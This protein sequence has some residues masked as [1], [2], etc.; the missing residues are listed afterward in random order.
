MVRFVTISHFLSLIPYPDAPSP[1]DASD[2]AGLV[3]EEGNESDEQD[4]DVEACEDEE[5]GEDEE[6]AGE[7][8]TFLSTA[9]GE[10][11]APKAESLGA[12][13]VPPDEFSPSPPIAPDVL[14]RAWGANNDW[15]E[16]TA[17][18]MEGEESAEE[19]GEYDHDGM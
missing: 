7:C 3:E 16:F 4:G 1:T 12:E 5:T 11:R 10:E 18:W 8:W 15:K 2:S 19:E 9:I 6:H 14:S 17:E 13:F